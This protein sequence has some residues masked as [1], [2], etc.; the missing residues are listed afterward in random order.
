[1]GFPINSLE[2]YTKLIEEKKYSYIVYNYDNVLNKLIVV[3][4]YDGKNK[5]EIKNDRNNC[6]ICTNTVKMYRKADKYVQAVLELYNTE[7][8]LEQFDFLKK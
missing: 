4:R 3:K 6:Y 7:E 5:N 1:M 8:E 2:K